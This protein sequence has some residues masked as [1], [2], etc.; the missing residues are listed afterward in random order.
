MNYNGYQQVQNWELKSKKYPGH[1]WV[2]WDLI[3]HTLK[4]THVG[5]CMCYSILTYAPYVVQC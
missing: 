5:K 1:Q 2:L 3:S 4:V